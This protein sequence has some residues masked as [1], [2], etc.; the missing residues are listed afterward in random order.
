MCMAIILTTR[1]VEALWVGHDGRPVP[2]AERTPELLRR[3]QAAHVAR[4]PATSAPQELADECEA[5]VGNGCWR[6]HCRCG[7]R[8]HADPEWGLA[9]CFGCG[10]IWTRVAFPVDRLAI[11]TLLVL[12]PVQA[13]RNW[14]QPETL[15]DLTQEQVAH[16]DPIV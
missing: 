1:H 5:Y 10:A 16:G 12:R 8:T 14:R 9:C 11:E 7:E 15:A 4:N 2:L 6:V 3:Q 13:T